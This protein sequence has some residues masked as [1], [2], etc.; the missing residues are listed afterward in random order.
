[1][2]FEQGHKFVCVF[3]GEVIV[4]NEILEGNLVECF[5]ENVGIV[6]HD[7]PCV[8][9]ENVMYERW[10]IPKSWVSVVRVRSTKKAC[11][12]TRVRDYFENMQ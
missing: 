8:L 1:M 12:K 4:Q 10:V 5:E 11:D 6:I 9:L 3:H 7:P 2:S